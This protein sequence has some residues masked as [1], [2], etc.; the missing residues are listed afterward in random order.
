[1][2]NG[3]SATDI[4]YVFVALKLLCAIVAGGLIGME[5]SFHGRPTGFRTHAIVCLSCA[6]VVQVVVH[7]PIWT[8]GAPP[9]M[10][11]TDATRIMQGILTGMGFLGAGVIFR[12][13]LTIRGLTT[14]A[15][16]WIT[17]PIGMLFGI[18]FFYIG[19]IT[20]VATILILTVFRYIE[21]FIHTRT[22]AHCMV[23]FARDSDVTE[24]QFKT[25]LVDHGL[26]MIGNMNYRITPDG[27]NCE[28]NLTV[29]SEKPNSYVRLSKTLR[30][31]PEYK[32]FSLEFIRD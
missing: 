29:R 3:L 15:S 6:A 24:E 10:L 11:R 26:E 13:G 1:M 27:E 17:A 23:S 8:Y 25:L 9:G 18:G 21:G 5:R 16:I 4:P 22:Y 32:A 7:L 19:A 20:T 12:E 14:S 30:Q 31:L 2:N 28:F